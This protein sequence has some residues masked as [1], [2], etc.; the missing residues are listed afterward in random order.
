MENRQRPH[1]YYS[2]P[3]LTHYLSPSTAVSTL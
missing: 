2:G 1:L 3:S